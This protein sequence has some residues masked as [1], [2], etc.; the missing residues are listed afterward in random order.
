MPLL[1]GGKVLTGIPLGVF[2]TIS[3][4]YC[5]EIAPFALR[6]AVTAAVNWSIVLGQSLAYLVMRQ[7]QNIPGPNS[8]R[9]L[10]AVQWLFAA[11]A[12][13]ILPFFPESPFFLVAQGRIDK[14]RVNVRRL[15]GPSFDAD[16][17]LASIKLD[18]ETQAR[19]HE[20][21]SFSEC[22]RGKNRLRTFIATSTFFLQSICGI[23]WFIG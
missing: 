12:L 8:Y 21:A 7:T 13:G 18:L 3:P 11:I 22:F 9:Y 14:A 4:T 19:I 5:A 20:E 23:S 1:F 16:G 6:G 17:F 2:I 15:H 10:F